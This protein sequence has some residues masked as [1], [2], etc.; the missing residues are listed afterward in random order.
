MSR[1]RRESAVSVQLTR[2][3]MLTVDVICR[4]DVICMVL[5][6]GLSGAALSVLICQTVNSHAFWAGG[7]PARGGR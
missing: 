5:D 2:C 7:T 6:D 3:V 4:A 1:Q